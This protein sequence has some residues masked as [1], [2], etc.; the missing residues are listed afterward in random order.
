MLDSVDVTVFD[1][2]EISPAE[3]ELVRPPDYRF[4]EPVIGVP[5][6]GSR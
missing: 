5:G 2:R 4:Q 6:G 3:S 1:M